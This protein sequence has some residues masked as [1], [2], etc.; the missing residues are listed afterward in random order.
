MDIRQLRQF[1]AVVETGSFTKAAQ[2]MLVAQPSLSQTIKGLERELGVALFHRIGRTVTL[3]EAGKELEGPAR[4]VLRNLEAAEARV[5]GLRDLHSG[6]VRIAAMPSPSIEPLTG[7]ISSFTAEHPH[8]VFDVDA[9]FTVEET[10]DSVR[11][12][13]AELGFLGSREHLNIRELKVVH[14]LDQPLMLAT[15]SSWTQTHSSKPV[16]H[17]DLDGARM[18]VSQKGS[19]MRFF[20]DEMIAKGVDISIVAEVAHRTSILPLVRAGVGHAI[21]PSSWSAFTSSSDVR[22]LPIRESPALHIS[23]ITRTD[24]LTPA[25]HH[26]FQQAVHQGL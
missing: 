12:G 17:R 1:L 4:L 24:G 6:R 8:I 16:E 19:L 11:Q 10:I 3:S 25:A 26:F 5:R 13:R 21:L 15:N 23:V 22:L 14:L 20:V 2:M 18:I 7:L 9:T